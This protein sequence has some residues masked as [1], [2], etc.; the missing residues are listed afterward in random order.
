MLNRGG[1]I[2]QRWNLQSSHADPADTAFPVNGP[3]VTG[4]RPVPQASPSWCCW[5]SRAESRAGSAASDRAQS[6]GPRYH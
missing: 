5:P 1:A 2:S 3:K 4:S 6:D